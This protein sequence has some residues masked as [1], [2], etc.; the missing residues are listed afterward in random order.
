MRYPAAGTTSFMGIQS[1]L[2]ANQL[3]RCPMAASSNSREPCVGAAA[4]RPPVLVST[5]GRVS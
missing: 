2:L 1:V 5:A 3:L 4:P